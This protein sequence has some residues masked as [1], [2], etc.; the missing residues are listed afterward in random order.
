MPG[1]DIGIDLGTYSIKFF[2]R[3]KGIILSEETAICYDSFTGETVAVGNDAGQMLDRLPESLILKCPIE[4]GVVS[5]FPSM[6]NIL[7]HFIKKVCKNRIFRPNLVIS[8]PCCVTSLEKKTVIEAACAAG[9]GKVH[10]T[11]EPIVSAIGAGLSIEHPHG[12]MVVD[13]GAGTTDIAVITM[14]TIACASSI[15]TAGASFDEA[16]SNYLKREKDIVAGIH[17]VRNIK[18]TVG[19]VFPREEEIEAVYSG[20]DYI[21]G[22]PRTFHVRANETVPALKEPLDIIFASILD[23]LEQTPPELYSDI[24]NEGILLT[25]GSAKLFGIDKELSARLGIKVTCAADSENCAAKGAGYILRNMK[26]LEDN[27]YTFRS[28][29]NITA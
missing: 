12:V 15:K 29:E 8:A 16:I 19:S 2:A 17:T 4:G 21:T 5:D 20:K 23:V 9:A 13:I 6:T 24:C 14:G 22:M 11:D 28:R 26:K 3:K 25:G 18:H 10:I 1:L 27:G 7:T